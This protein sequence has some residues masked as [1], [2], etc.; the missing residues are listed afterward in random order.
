MINLICFIIFITYLAI[1]F[2]LGYMFLKDRK[3]FNIV[4][5]NSITNDINNF[6]NLCNLCD[7]YNLD[8]KSKP[9]LDSIKEIE[10]EIEME[11]ENNRKQIE[12]LSGI[13]KIFKT[14]NKNNIPDTNLFLVEYEIFN[15]ML[16]CI[17]RDSQKIST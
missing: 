4:I 2:Y 6:C 15:W 8:G 13:Y 3:I 16:E 5:I 10:M 12:I 17:I 11:I 14:I 9:S 1:C 7:L